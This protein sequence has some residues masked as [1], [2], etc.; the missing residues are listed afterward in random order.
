MKRDAFKNLHRR[1]LLSKMPLTMG[2]ADDIV[3]SKDDSGTSFRY[4]SSAIK[5]GHKMGVTGQVT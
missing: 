2:I 1:S 5:N 4:S 3:V